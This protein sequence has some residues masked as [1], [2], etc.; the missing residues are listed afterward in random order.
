MKTYKHIFFDL[1]RTLWDMD[2]NAS[3]TL[4][5]LF[6]RYRLPEHGIE[7][8]E[9]FIRHYNEYNDVLW[10]RYRRK[11]IDKA[12]LRA[13]RFKQTLAHFGVHDK[14]LAARF[15]HDYVTEAPNKTNLIPGAKELLNELTGKFSLHIITNGFPE[16]QHHK[17]KNCGIEQYFEQVIT[18]EG[19][20]Y[21]KPDV[22]IFEY[23]L[24]K[25]GGKKEEALMIG[26]DLHVDILGA[27]N[28]G[29]DSVFFNITGASHDEE[30][31]YEIRELMEVKNILAC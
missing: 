6:Y 20:G 27:K 18:S 9:V 13:L 22:R 30:V 1:D 21:N 14:E 23:S 12:T 11:L 28:A 24:R 3:E 10:D 4:K 15:D 25:S 5:E 17:I 7:D 2:H 8:A 31:Q 19:C 26:D 29:W 16:V